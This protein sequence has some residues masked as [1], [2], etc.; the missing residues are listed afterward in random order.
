MRARSHITKLITLI[1]VGAIQIGSGMNDFNE[2]QRHEDIDSAKVNFSCHS[3][4]PKR[5]YR[6]VE[7][8]ARSLHLAD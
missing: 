4:I 1:Y 7:I 8:E 5:C 3:L 2:L 6:I